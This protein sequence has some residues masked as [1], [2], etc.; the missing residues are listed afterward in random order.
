MPT[1]RKALLGRYD[2]HT[3]TTFSDG[4]N[5]VLENARA[6]EACG[7]ET[8]IIT[9]HVFGDAPWLGNMLREVEAADAACATKVLAGA[10]GV[11]L[12]PAGEISITEEIAAR[13]DFVLV[14]FGGRT[15]GIAA[16]PP[17]NQARLIKN[18]VSAVT[19][20]CANPLVD[21]IA[22]PLNLGRFPAVLS[23]VDFKAAPLIEMA[24]A[25]EETRTAFEIMNQLPWWFP[26]HSVERITAEYADVLHLFARFGV[27][28]IVG[29][30]A[31]SCGAVGNLRWC[32]RVMA[33][34][35]LGD[36]HLIDIPLAGERRKP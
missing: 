32:E 33:A 5:S 8:L 21:A 34:A 16:D 10:E 2:A 31:H 24:T 35:G 7:L 1:R 29:S 26:D 3:H 22:H 19:K 15:E 20:A 17:A 30:D 18:V 28:F 9:D 4:R 36:E 11:I 12:N 6:A 13:L 23:P 25:F 14:D 27:R